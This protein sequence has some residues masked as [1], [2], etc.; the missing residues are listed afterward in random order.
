M[1][2]RK[3]LVAL[4]ILL[5]GSYT[6]AYIGTGRGTKSTKMADVLVSI[7][8]LTEVSNVFSGVRCVDLCLQNE[9]CVS[10]FYRRQH[11][12]CQLHDVLFM[13]PQDGEQETGTVYYSVTTGDCPSGYVH[14]RLLNF[15]YQLHPER[16][17]YDDGL[18]DCT[19][20]GEH[21]VVIDSADKQNHVVKQIT[22]SSVT[23]PSY[24]IDGSDAANEGHWVFHDGRNMT[25][26]L[27]AQGFPLTS[28]GRNCMVADRKDE[29]LW[30]D[31]AA[32][33]DKCYICG[34]DV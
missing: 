6:S 18:A 28:N 2:A 33:G 14:N 25:F 12:R 27:W 34:R 5:T 26:F 24:Y 8:I 7:N 29:F 31:S 4:I 17:L 9:A 11:R 20:R 13:T 3:M 30:H 23:C 19:S 15:C 1:S 16:I 22:S 21:L 10:V 32:M